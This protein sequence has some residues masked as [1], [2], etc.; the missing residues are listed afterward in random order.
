MDPV[1]PQPGETEDAV[2]LAAADVE[3]AIA[4]LLADANGLP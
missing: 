4:A 2:T 3:A 1:A